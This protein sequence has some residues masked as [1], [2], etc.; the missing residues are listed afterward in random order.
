MQ[1][2]RRT[3]YHRVVSLKVQ[4][5]TLRRDCYQIRDLDT[6]CMSLSAAYHWTRTILLLMNLLC[7]APP[8]VTTRSVCREKKCNRIRS[9]GVEE[10]Y[11]CEC[12]LCTVNKVHK[13]LLLYYLLCRL[14]DQDASKKASTHKSISVS[15]EPIS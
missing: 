7:A 14:V 9:V 8:N 10:A 15:L 1:R 2:H 6:S 11:W 4:Q 5:N 13:R 12:A 3:V